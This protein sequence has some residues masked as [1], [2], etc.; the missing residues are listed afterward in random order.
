MKKSFLMTTPPPSQS[1][2]TQSQ[3]PKKQRASIQK[4]IDAY[5]AKKPS[6][7]P[8]QPTETS[9]SQPKESEPTTQPEKP[10][11][12]FTGP[13]I[14]P[15]LP[16]RASSPPT[17]AEIRKARD[18]QAEAAQWGYEFTL[19]GN[20]TQEQIR[21]IDDPYSELINAG[22]SPYTLAERKKAKAREEEYYRSLG[23]ELT[24]TPL[25]V[26]STSLPELPE[27]PE[28]LPE[29]LIEPVYSTEQQSDQPNTTSEESARARIIAI[30]EEY[31]PILNQEQS[32][33]PLPESSTPL[34]E[35]PIAPTY[36][37]EQQ[38]SQLH[39]T[40]ESLESPASQ[41]P[42]RR[43]LPTSR[44]RQIVDKMSHELEE[45]IMAPNTIETN[46]HLNRVAVEIQSRDITIESDNE[47]NISGD[48]NSDAGNDN[49]ADETADQEPDN[50]EASPSDDIES[51]ND[52]DPFD[53]T[54]GEGEDNGTPTARKTVGGK[55]AP[56]P[57]GK[58]KTITI[59]SDMLVT[60]RARRDGYPS[61]LD[62]PWPPFTFNGSR[63]KDLDYGH[64][65]CPI[66]YAQLRTGNYTGQGT[67]PW[68][69]TEA[70]HDVK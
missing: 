41:S 11:C 33:I 68:T 64:P 30:S 44:P 7:L 45:T 47:E 17:F 3:A 12:T 57:R 69:F 52:D 34:P 28:L 67:K 14:D 9:Q 2:D 63:I 6:A 60:K 62:W 5:L 50:F 54:N 27:L 66:D 18:D 8:E 48:E 42:S 51:E 24:T 31:F 58:A 38:S 61:I 13:R 23:Y 65:E 15:I 36:A 40:S 35:L 1:I 22:A 4:P 16:R 46:G 55:G 43:P 53:E 19:P 26:L 56:L 70:M 20:V 32:A 10:S 21:Q 25:E 49:D 39:N 59:T 37:T 29:P